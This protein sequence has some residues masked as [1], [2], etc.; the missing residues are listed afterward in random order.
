VWISD[1]EAGVG[2]VQSE[3]LNHLWVSFKENGIELPFPQRD[4]RIKEWPEPPAR[5]AP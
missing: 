2:N 5:P 1:P 4:I 3:I